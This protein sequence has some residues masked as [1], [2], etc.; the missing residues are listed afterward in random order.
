MDLIQ[1]DGNLLD[2]SN[3]KGLGRTRRWRRIGLRRRLIRSISCRLIANFGIMTDYVTIVA[4]FVFKF[5]RV[6]NLLCATATRAWMKSLFSRSLRITCSVCRVPL[7]VRRTLRIR[8]GTSLT[9]CGSTWL[10]DEMCSCRRGLSLTWRANI[11]GE[12]FKCSRLFEKIGDGVFI[13]PEQYHL[14]ASLST[15]LI[16]SSLRRSL[17][18]PP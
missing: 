17:W 2:V 6:S 7:C 5:A 12:L 3:E 10:L 14:K 16:S 13:W 11:S 1:L 9:F 18:L 15:R 4:L 8:L